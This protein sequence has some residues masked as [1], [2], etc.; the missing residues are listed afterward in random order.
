MWR[1]HGSFVNRRSDVHRRRWG[2][3]DLLLL[4]LA[5]ILALDGRGNLSCIHFILFL[6]L[7][8]WVENARSRWLIKRWR[9]LVVLLLNNWLICRYRS[10]QN[11]L[12]KSLC[13]LLILGE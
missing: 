8:C 10:S 9:R 5:L 4:G 11:W 3:N 13:D 12:G 2:S 1:W 7:V 6:S